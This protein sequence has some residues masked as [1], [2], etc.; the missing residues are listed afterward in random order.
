MLHY[1]HPYVNKTPYEII[2]KYGIYCI[3]SPNTSDSVSGTHVNIAPEDSTYHTPVYL[4][5]YVA[6]HLHLVN[7]RTLS[8][9]H[10]LVF[11]H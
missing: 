11:A 6:S 4:P 3:M 9:I 7:P 1:T 5:T 2:D 10:T 8:I